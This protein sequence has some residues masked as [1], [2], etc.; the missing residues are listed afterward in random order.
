MVII[1]SEGQGPRAVGMALGGKGTEDHA[2]YR[3]LGASSQLIAFEGRPWVGVRHIR[4][5]ALMVM[6]RELSSSGGSRR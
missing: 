2:N 5:L 4:N 6:A 3:Q 1:G